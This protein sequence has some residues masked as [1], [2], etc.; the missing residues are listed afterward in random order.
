MIVVDASIAAKWMVEEPGRLDAL[1]ILDLQE[2]IVAPDLIVPEVAS[3]FRKKVIRG[4]MTLAQAEAGLS[5]VGGLIGRFVPCAGLA[6]EAWALSRRLDHSVY[7]CFYLACAVP[8]ARLVS[9]DIRFVDKCRAAGFAD[10]VLS[11]AN[12]ESLASKSP[13]R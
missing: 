6:M 4:E 9:A 3:V 5:A 12:V 10:I 2:E 1:K 7:D 11:P 8:S 13:L